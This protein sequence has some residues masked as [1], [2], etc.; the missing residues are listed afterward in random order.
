MDF[1]Y[2]QELLIELDVDK[3]ENV[4]HYACVAVSHGGKIEW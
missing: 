3:I 1:V 2:S 4:V